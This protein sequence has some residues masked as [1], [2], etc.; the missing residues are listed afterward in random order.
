MGS[1][2][3]KRNKN[4]SHLPKVGTATEEHYE[5]EHARDAV[6]ENF[7]IRPSSRTARLWAVVGVVIVLLAVL[8]IVGW[9]VMT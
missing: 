5:L 1:S 6:V 2:G 7:G 9:V 4:R 3:M 8:A